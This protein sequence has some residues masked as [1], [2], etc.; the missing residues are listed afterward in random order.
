MSENLSRLAVEGTEITVR[1][2]PKASRNA[3]KVEDG[4]I[5][6]YVT[7][8]PEGGKANAAVQKLLAK[9][10]GLAKSRLVL[11]RGQT[12]RDKTFLVSS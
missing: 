4:Q 6:V 10:M 3:V 2:T 5:R 12:A 11:I 8:V 9:Q 1:V 7:T